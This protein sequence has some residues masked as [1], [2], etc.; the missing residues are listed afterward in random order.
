[1]RRGRGRLLAFEAREFGIGVLE[2]ADP[3]AG[4]RMVDGDVRTAPH[5]CPAAARRALRVVA[6]DVVPHARHREGG[7]QHDHAGDDREDHPAPAPREHGSQ[8]DAGRERGEARL[9]V[10]EVQAGPDRGDRGRRPKHHP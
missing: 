8:D 4:D 10:G 6:E 7:R 2:A 5:E 9:R 1:V 3:D